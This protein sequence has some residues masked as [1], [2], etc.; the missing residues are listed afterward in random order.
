[1]ACLDA[2]YAQ[3]VAYDCDVI[4][5]DERFVI[6]NFERDLAAEKLLIDSLFKAVQYLDS[7]MLNWWMSTL[8]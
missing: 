4:N 2:P 5:E 3:W 7:V 8:Y 6:I 1:M